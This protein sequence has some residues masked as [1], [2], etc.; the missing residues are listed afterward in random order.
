MEPLLRAPYLEQWAVFFVFLQASLLGVAYYRS[1]GSLFSAIIDSGRKTVIGSRIQLDALSNTLLY[2]MS[3][4]GLILWSAW[5]ISAYYYVFTAIWMSLFFAILLAVCWHLDYFLFWSMESRSKL[6]S[7]YAHTT[8]MYW[9]VLGISLLFIDAYMVFNRDTAVGAWVFLFS[10]CFCYLLRTINSI[11]FAL[12]SGFSWY[13][14]ILYLCT[15]NILPVVIINKL[16]VM[17]WPTL[18]NH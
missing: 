17:Y 11:T 6:I 14:I 16:F 5:Q 10:L 1:E 4:F 12:A 3:A 9:F 13:Y 8:R 18:T 15:V 2:G 7:Q